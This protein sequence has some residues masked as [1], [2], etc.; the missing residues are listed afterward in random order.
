[1]K[2]SDFFLWEF[3]LTEMYVCDSLDIFF[4]K[5]LILK[6][7]LKISNSILIIV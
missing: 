1:M 4:L 3:F 6:A 7:F 5:M 2:P